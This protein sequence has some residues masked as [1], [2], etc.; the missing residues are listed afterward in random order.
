MRLL[1]TFSAI[2]VMIG[3][4]APLSAADHP[5]QHVP[6]GTPSPYAAGACAAPEYG[7]EAFQSGCGPC[8][9]NCCDDVW[10]GY[11]QEKNNGY[12][13]AI[14]CL[15]GWGGWS[16]PGIL[17]SARPCSS[18]PAS[19]SDADCSS[20]NVQTESAQPVAEQPAARSAPMP[21]ARTRRA[22]APKPK[23]QP[24]PPP[25]EEPGK[26]KPRENKT[27]QADPAYAPLFNPAAWTIGS[28]DR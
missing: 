13:F 8:G 11:C 24:L 2:L 21:P 22:P 1:I 10:A 26:R 7:A 23:V 18:C 19:P 9:P 3:V 6:P 20:C 5:D 28:P 16:R 17:R 25:P 4:A 12:G 27:T 14:P 15:P